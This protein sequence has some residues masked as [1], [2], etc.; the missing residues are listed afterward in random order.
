MLT[1]YIVALVIHGTVGTVRPP[2][3]PTIFMAFDNKSDCRAA[4]DHYIEMPS[5]R[6][7]AHDRELLRVEEC[8]SLPPS[9]EKTPK[10]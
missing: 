3:E 9:R 2:A 1:W 6:M 10:N 5:P 4:Y 7:L 8:K